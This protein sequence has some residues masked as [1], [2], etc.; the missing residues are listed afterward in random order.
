MSDTE[1][2]LQKKLRLRKM[3]ILI[4]A[5]ECIMFTIQ[6]WYGVFSVGWHEQTARLIAI[7]LMVLY[8]FAIIWSFREGNL[9]FDRIMIFISWGLLIISSLFLMIK[10]R[11]MS[12]GFYDLYAVQRES[13]INPGFSLAWLFFVFISFLLIPRYTSYS[14]KSFAL[15]FL[16]FIV[17]I[18]IRFLVL[19]FL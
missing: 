16:P 5:Y 9:K 14:L 15:L 6:L 3:I 17:W 19:N 7:A 10:P 18:L 13:V 12:N 1:D 4:F 2:K 11:V 8:P